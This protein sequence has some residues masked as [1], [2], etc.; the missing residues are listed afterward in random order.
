M[1]AYSAVLAPIVVF[2]SLL[3][4][5]VSDL[6][7]LDDYLSVLNFLNAHV[8][9]P[10]VGMRIGHLLTTQHNEYRLVF[11]SA[12]FWLQY[13]LMGGVNFQVL[14]ALGNIFVLLIFVLL[15]QVSFPGTSQEVRAML[16]VPAAF[17]L[18]QLQYASTLNWAM[19]GLQNLPVLF[20]AFLALILLTRDGSL[21]QTR[22]FFACAVIAVLLAIASSGNGFIAGC[23]GGLI[24]LQR[25][26]LA[27][28]LVWSGAIVLAF[29]AY[30]YRYDFHLAQSH[31]PRGPAPFAVVEAILYALSFLGASAA[32]TQSAIPATLLGVA[33]CAAFA[34]MTRRRFW[35]RNAAVYFIFVFLLLSALGVA[36]LRGPEGL[37]QS[38]ASRYRIYSNLAL[39]L[40]YVFAANEIKRT[41][42]KASLRTF[43]LLS[44]FAGVV[45]CVA[46]DFAGYHYLKQ[47]RD[48]L[49]LG[50]S[51]WQGSG[52]TLAVA[53]SPDDI[54]E[55]HRRAGI[56]RPIPGVLKESERLGVYSVPT[57]R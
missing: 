2:Y 21:D 48:E 37:L 35:E 3:A 12:I 52:A 29:A 27:R 41:Q 33:L 17:F 23:V 34:W 22:V 16:L 51:E 39:L 20:F 8:V 44:T 18:F 42:S 31:P 54:L 28:L 25:K 13:D 5:T 9:L 43:L 4:L 11:E 26:Q 46:S 30:L 45:F 55:R 19:G 6:P 57:S 24:L 32:R 38:L 1:L 56:Y 10:T 36:F 15:W 50:M 7:F 14:C 40:T 53:G 47:R 49:R